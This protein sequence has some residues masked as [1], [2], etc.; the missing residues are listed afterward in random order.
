[1]RTKHIDIQHHYIRDKDTSGRI[2]LNVSERSNKTPFPCEVSEFYYGDAHGVR[3]I[4]TAE[5]WGGGGGGG[6]VV[7]WIIQQV[8]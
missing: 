2:N 4:R 7:E 1:M 3:A 8:T 5:L 6:G